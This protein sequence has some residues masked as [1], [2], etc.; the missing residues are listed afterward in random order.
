MA[1]TTGATGADFAEEA[2][3]LGSASIEPGGEEETAFTL[4]VST[5]G[6]REP[7]ST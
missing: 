7:T 3:L 2:P 1:R 6:A 5:T 4:Y